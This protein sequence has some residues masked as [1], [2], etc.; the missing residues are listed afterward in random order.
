MSNSTGSLGRVVMAGIPGTGKSTYLGALYHVIESVSDSPITLDMLPAL[1]DHLEKLRTNWLAVEPESRTS[2][3]GPVPSELL[4]S[5]AD[6]SFN[7]NWPDL[8]GE[9]FE[10]MVLTRTIRPDV[11]RLV[12]DAT[13]MMLF[14]HPTKITSEPRI[15]D[16]KAAANALE[17]IELDAEPQPEPSESGDPDDKAI[18]W[19]PSMVPGEI[20][21]IELMQQLMSIAKPT[22]LN[23]IAV[24]ISAWD[25]I[26]DNCPS[27][28]V[29]LDSVLPLFAQFLAANKQIYSIEVF[30]VSAHGGDPIR[31]KDRLQQ[32]VKA[33]DRISVVGYEG[34]L[35]DS[36]IVAP[37]AW[38]L[39]KQ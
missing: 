15:D 13:A 39:S 28:K 12:M 38:L 5:T 32:F 20:V 16:I 21:A 8:S 4:V 36:G 1:R 29:Y 19:D 14:I 10:E 35:L 3:A 30:G 22:K 34:V 7:L 24:I 2:S 11:H 37:L 6:A 18:D 25:L 33:T 27:P 23:K 17:E 9:F 26:P 31:E